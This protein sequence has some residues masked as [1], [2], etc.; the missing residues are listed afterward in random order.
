MTHPRYR[1]LLG[2]A[3][4]ALF[5]G[6]AIAQTTSDNPSHP[7]ASKG[8]PQ[9][10]QT[11]SAQQPTDKMK[12][13]SEVQAPAS[14]QANGKASASDKASNKTSVANQTEKKASAAAGKEASS[15]KTTKRTKQASKARDQTTAALDPG[16]KAFRQALRQC[17]KEQQQSERDTCLDSAIEQ[18]QR[19]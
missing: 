13:P 1:M 10:Q 4:A 12:G 11:Q 15:A 6:A 14:D 3:L 2:T 8:T 7:A 16:E 5:I 18:F 9:A 17:A 19:G